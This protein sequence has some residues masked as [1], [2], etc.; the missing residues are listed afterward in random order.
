MSLASHSILL[1]VPSPEPSQAIQQTR[2]RLQRL[3]SDHWLASARML[4]RLEEVRFNPDGG[5]SEIMACDTAFVDV[6]GRRFGQAP[7][8]EPF[9]LGRSTPPHIPCAPNKDASR[10]FVRSS[11]RHAFSDSWRL[12]SSRVHTIFRQT[13]FPHSLSMSPV[14]VHLSAFTAARRILPTSGFPVPIAISGLFGLP[15]PS[16]NGM[17]IQRVRLIR[18][19]HVVSDAVGVAEASRSRKRERHHDISVEIHSAQQDH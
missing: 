3:G 17:R 18:R 8:A 15:T 1:R 14:A 5:R 10:R 11:G 19:R 6:P 4:A 16:D 7:V 12:A 13:P 9:R 2:M